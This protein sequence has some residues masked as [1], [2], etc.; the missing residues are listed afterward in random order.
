MLA[1][2]FSVMARSRFLDVVKAGIAD[3]ELVA[4]PQDKAEPYDLDLSGVTWL[5]A[6]GSGPVDRVETAHPPGGA[7]APRRSEVETTLRH[8]CT[9]WI[10]F[11]RGP[12]A[13]EFDVS[14]A[15]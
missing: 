13:G 1:I 3:H 2:M 4:S 12:R 7:T 6:A 5:G 11:R 8:T 10:A 15:V 9:E 14:T